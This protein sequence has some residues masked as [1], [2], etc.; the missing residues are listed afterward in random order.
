[1]VTVPHA[2]GYDVDTIGAFFKSVEK[3]LYVGL[4]CA[5]Q[6]DDLNVGGIFVP[7]RTGCIGGHVGA[8]DAGENSDFGGEIFRGSHLTSLGRSES[9]FCGQTVTQLPHPVQAQVSTNNSF[10]ACTQINAV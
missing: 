4:S 2:A 8:V 9:A 1:M 6:A 10:S 3:I 5:G 7:Q